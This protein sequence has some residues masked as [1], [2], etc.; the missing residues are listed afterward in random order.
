[1]SAQ[2]SLFVTQDG[3]SCV[4]WRRLLPERESTVSRTQIDDTRRLSLAPLTALGR[5]DL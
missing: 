3:Y 1:M 4:T 2:R 5:C